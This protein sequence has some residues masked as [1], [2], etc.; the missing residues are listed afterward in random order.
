[1]RSRN[2]IGHV[3]WGDRSRNLTRRPAPERPA[4]TPVIYDSTNPPPVP[5]VYFIE[6]GGYVKIG[7]T[8]N[9]PARVMSGMQLPPNARVAALIPGVGE[10]RES[11]LHAMFAASRQGRG[12]K[13]FTRSPELDALIG[14]FAV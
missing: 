13:W 6:C 1:M 12:S 14:A 5:S 3:P 10:Q 8:M 2:T 11:E 7:T 4:D 9:T